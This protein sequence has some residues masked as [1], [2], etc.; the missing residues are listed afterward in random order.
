M[1]GHISKHNLNFLNSKMQ[2]EAYQKLLKIRPTC[3][4]HGLP[5]LW[6]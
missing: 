3:K 5:P 4:R 1:T 2:L 6:P